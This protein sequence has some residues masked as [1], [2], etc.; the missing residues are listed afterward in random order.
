MYRCEVCGSLYEGKKI[1]CDVCGR[2]ICSEC[3][4]SFDE[5]SETLICIECLNEMEEKI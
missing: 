4:G 5:T 3:V 1:E 2:E